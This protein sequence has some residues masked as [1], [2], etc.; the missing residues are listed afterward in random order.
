MVRLHS[1]PHDNGV[2]VSVFCDMTHGGWTVI[3]RRLNGSVDFY[4][5]WNDY[6]RGFGSR[7]LVLSRRLTAVNG[8][9]A[10]VVVL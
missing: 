9:V 1:A 5:S 7:L 4:R 2:D 3:Q 8:N 6:R 10:F